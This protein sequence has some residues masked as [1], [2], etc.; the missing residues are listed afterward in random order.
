M[1]VELELLEEGLAAHAA[2]EVLDPGV[3][4]PQVPIKMPLLQEGRAAIGA[5][6]SP[7]L[8]VVDP[9]VLQ[10][11][12]R[13]E[14]LVALR[15]RVAPEVDRPGCVR[16]FPDPVLLQV[17][18]LLEAATAVLASERIFLRVSQQMSET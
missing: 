3:D 18:Q 5:R 6:K 13:Q 15:T 8:V 2:E 4:P 17:D 9:V 7:D 12:R 16:V 1:V 11:R 10:L 14:H